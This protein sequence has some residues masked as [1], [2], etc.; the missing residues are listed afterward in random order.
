MCAFCYLGR[1]EPALYHAKNCLEICEK[2]KI[3]DF[4]IAFA[5]EGIAKGKRRC[6]A[7]SGDKKVPRFGKE[8]SRPN[9]EERG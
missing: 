5:Y 7:E 9:Q 1:S 6:T 2:N 4:N 8:G 3:G